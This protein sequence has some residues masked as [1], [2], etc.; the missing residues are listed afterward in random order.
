[1]EKD[2]ECEEKLLEGI[3]AMTEFVV[4]KRWG[5][6]ENTTRIIPKLPTKDLTRFGLF[7]LVDG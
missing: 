7:P 1:L 5:V 3:S 6:V 2:R 4:I